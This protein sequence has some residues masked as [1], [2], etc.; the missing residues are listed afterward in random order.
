LGDAQLIV[1]PHPF[2]NQRELKALFAPFAP[3]V[4]LQQY[5]PDEQRRLRSQDEQE[6][7]EWVN[8]FRHGDVVVH[9]SSTVAIDAA[10]F[11][12]PSVC[13]DYDPAPG[14]P[15]QA[16]VRDVNHRW[17]HY[18][19][20]AESGGT[21]LVNNPDELVSA[22]RAYLADPS[23]DRAERRQMA[24]YVCGYLDGQC[25]QRMVNAVLDFRNGHFSKSETLPELYARA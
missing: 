7:D 8:T 25:G 18:K 11:D 6:T 19:P 20:V 12:R 5:N 4:V 1:R 2:H 23:L 3:R 17:T 14:Q 9:L 24:G 21:R 13:M 10:L 22:V 15:H 16:I